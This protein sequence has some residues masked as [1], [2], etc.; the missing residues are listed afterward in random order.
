MGQIRNST[1]VYII[2]ESNCD[3]LNCRMGYLQRHLRYVLILAQIFGILPVYGISFDD[4][5]KLKFSW[6]SWRVLYA[7]WL[8]LATFFVAFMAFF[9]LCSNDFELNNLS[10]YLDL[11]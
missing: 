4:P 1:A 8:I 6:Q 5:L 9:N 11:I 2:E 3:V 10:K 7:C